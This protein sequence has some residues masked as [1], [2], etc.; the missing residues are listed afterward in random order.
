MAKSHSDRLMVNSTI[1]LAHSLGQ[2]VVAEGVEEPETLETLAGMGC[3]IAQGFLIARP[4][5]F[6]DL[7]RYLLADRKRRAA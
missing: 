4:M 6:R 3:D 1:Q 5:P 2:K 7:M